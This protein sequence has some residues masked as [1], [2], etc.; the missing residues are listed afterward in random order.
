[1][2]P[3]ISE[4]GLRDDADAQNRGEE[5]THQGRDRQRL[6]DPGDRKRPTQ[7]RK[8]KTIE[9]NAAVAIAHVRLICL[10]CDEVIVRVWMLQTTRPRHNRL[11]GL[12][13]TWT[14]MQ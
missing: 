3:N 10:N 4:R 5:K 9:G 8:A 7:T 2:L 12:G 14:S 13:K 1:V 6:D 11:A